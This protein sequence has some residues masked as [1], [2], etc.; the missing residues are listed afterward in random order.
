MEIQLNI[1]N[2]DE[3]LDLIVLDIVFNGIPRT[4]YE[5]SDH[6][7]T[8]ADLEFFSTFSYG[9]EDSFTGVGANRTFTRISTQFVSQ[10]IQ[11]YGV[12]V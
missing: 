5:R 3:L 1:L 9:K 12:P 6:F 11:L 10:M 2:N 7:N 8:M 4:V